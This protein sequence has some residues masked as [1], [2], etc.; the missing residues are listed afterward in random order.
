MLRPLKDL[1]HGFVVHC[2]VDEIAREDVI[3][4][5]FEFADPVRRGRIGVSSP[6]EAI[7]RDHDMAAKPFFFLAARYYGCA[8]DLVLREILRKVVYDLRVRLDRE[9]SAR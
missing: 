4:R 1:L 8:L 7:Q 2:V 6:N 3:H 5:S 9:I